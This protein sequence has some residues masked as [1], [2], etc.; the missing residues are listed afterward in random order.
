VRHNLET[1]LEVSLPG[2][3][4]ALG[5]R[6]EGIEC[7]I[8]YAYRLPSSA[9]GFERAKLRGWGLSGGGDDMLSDLTTVALAE[10]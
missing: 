3:T 8:C 6:E 1:L 9:G 2:P 7:S 5:E 10:V 4:A